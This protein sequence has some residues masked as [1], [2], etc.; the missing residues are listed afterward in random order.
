MRLLA[1]ELA[2][3]VQQGAAR[4]LVQR[5]P[6]R[7][8][9]QCAGKSP[10]P[11]LAGT[12]DAGAGDPSKFD[13]KVDDAQKARSTQLNAAPP[14]S[15]GAALKARLGERA[16]H[17]ENLLSANGIPLRPEVAGFFV[18]P[19][20]DP[21]VVGASTPRCKDFPG[22]SPGKPPAP[23]DKFCVELP[24][25]SE[26]QAKGLDFIGPRTKE[27]AELTQEFLREGVHEMQHAKFDAVQEDPAKRTIGPAADCNLDTLV[28]PHGY[29]VEYF[30]TE[31]S[32]ITSEFPV[33]FQNIAHTANPAEG[34]ENEE[35]SQAFNGDESL[36]GA[37]A[38]LQCGCSCGTVA[39]FVTKTVNETTA[40]WPPAQLNAYLRTMTLRLPAFWPKALKRS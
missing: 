29:P 13:K 21:N 6:C 9:A 39:S 34:L 20:S 4:D 40:G 35:Q 11:S 16:V 7:T 36:C 23:D 2:H 5:A 14:G 22:G 15:P 1:H 31:I 8:P 38:G 17:F 10:C 33:F 30:L 19:T 32:A 26:D 25:E 28:P 18:D 24:A 37:I 3:V 12:P 27:Q